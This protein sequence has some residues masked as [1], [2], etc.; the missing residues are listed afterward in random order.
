MF[1]EES[2]LLLAK[3]LATL[4][5]PEPGSIIFGSDGGNPIKLLKAEVN[6][7][8]GRFIL[9][10]SPESWRDLWDGRVFKKGSV[11]VEANLTERERKAGDPPP[12]ITH[13]LEWS[14][15]RL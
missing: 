5:S 9:L 2:Q 13:W 4:L 8:P 3:Q 11:K 12:T 14:V 6:T 15:T 10:H 7:A 1:S